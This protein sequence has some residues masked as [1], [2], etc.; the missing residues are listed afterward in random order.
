MKKK[1]MPK[2]ANELVQ[3]PVLFV[4]DE[5]IIHQNAAA[6]R[7]M[8]NIV[9]RLE[10]CLMPE[11]LESY[12]RFD[13]NGVL[14][15]TIRLGPYSYGVVITREPDW[16][17]F[18]AGTAPIDGP[19]QLNVFKSISRVMR[20]TL[21]EIEDA[22]FGKILDMEEFEK[23][24]MRREAARIQ[25]GLFQMTR[26]S[27]NLFDLAALQAA[28]RTAV[29][30]NIDLVSE[31]QHLTGILE[32]LCE[33]SGIQISFHSDEK[34]FS[35]AVDQNLFERAVLNIVSNAIR[36]CKAK[37]ESE[38]II[39]L[40]LRR[41]GRQGILMISDNGCGMDISK[42]DGIMTPFSALSDPLDNPDNGIGLGLTMAHRIAILHGGTMVVHT[43]PK[44]GTIVS[45]S[46]SA[47]LPN[48]DL[49]ENSVSSSKPVLPHRRGMEQV[50]LELSD[51]LPTDVFYDMV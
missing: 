24:E 23:P 3:Q 45:I 38:G 46:F 16:D 1:I 20:Q 14:L 33:R 37:G 18:I 41:E 27:D 40:Q 43:V 22:F 6:T 29:I 50:V 31:F 34:H 48:I 15:L 47:K 8:C 19:E 25:K 5:V 49:N 28:D 35:C 42:L 51:V 4:K 17:T 21:N 44:M 11:A 9:P 30:R 13:G 2:W 10:E 32:P 39:Q 7:L 26:L 12:R 36:G